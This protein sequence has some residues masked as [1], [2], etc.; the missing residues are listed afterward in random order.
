MVLEH[1][2]ILGHGREIFVAKE[3]SIDLAESGG[4]SFGI[5]Q[6][7]DRTIDLLLE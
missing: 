5:I 3:L 6:G 7:C 4:G 1:H 2:Q